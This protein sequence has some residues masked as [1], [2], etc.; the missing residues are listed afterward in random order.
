MRV[1]LSSMFVPVM[2]GL[3]GALCVALVISIMKCV[4]RRRLKKIKYYGGKVSDFIS[5]KLQTFNKVL[6]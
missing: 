3:L 2:S 6:C 4:R 1:V 5:I